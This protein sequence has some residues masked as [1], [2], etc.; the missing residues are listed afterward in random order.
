MKDS[1][2]GDTI[3][4]VLD[5]EEYKLL[6]NALS[7]GNYLVENKTL[8]KSIPIDKEKYKELSMKIVGIESEF[9]LKSEINFWADNFPFLESD[10]LSEEE[11]LKLIKARHEGLAG[12][13]FLWLSRMFTMKSEA[14]Y[15]AKMGGRAK[16]K[17]LSDKGYWDWYYEADVSDIAWSRLRIWSEPY[18]QELRKNGIKNLKFSWWVRLKISLWFPKK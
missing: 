6:R 4:I 16:L 1:G 8:S 13:S 10:N 18:L 5:K 15:Q 2:G 14:K 9:N 17:M 11:R 3:E 7:I 12:F